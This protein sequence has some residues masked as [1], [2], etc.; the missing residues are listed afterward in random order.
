MIQMKAC[1]I[2]LLLLF[3]FSY[4][5]TNARDHNDNNKNIKNINVK[6]NKITWWQDYSFLYI[7]LYT[8]AGKKCKHYLKSTNLQLATLFFS[9]IL[10]PDGITM[11]S[12][13]PIFNTTRYWS[14]D[15]LVVAQQI[16]DVLPNMRIMSR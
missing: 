12:L 6:N 10:L 5:H 9:L 13:Y 4:A 2:V 14:I 11:F 8:D 15:H 3:S 16:C 1:C 7:N